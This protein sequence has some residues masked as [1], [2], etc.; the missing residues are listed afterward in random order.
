VIGVDFAANAA[1]LGATVQTAPDAAGL[2]RA[3]AAARDRDG[4]SVI[5]V[6]VDRAARSPGYEAWWD[7]PVAQVSTL[8]SVEAVRPG[9][10][11][12]RAKVRTLI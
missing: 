1:S 6:P 5:V 9:Y 3:L 10:V 4:V 11:E 8:E 2:E 7:V 12:N